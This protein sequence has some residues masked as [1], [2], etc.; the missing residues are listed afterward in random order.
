[1]NSVKSSIVKATLLIISANTMWSAC[2][3]YSINRHIG[4]C[5]EEMRPAIEYY[6][7][8]DNMPE[9]SSV[10]NTETT[11]MAN[12]E[13]S[14]QQIEDKYLKTTYVTKMYDIPN[15]DTSFKSYM[16]YKCITN[17]K[18]EQ[19]KLQTKAWTDDDGLRRFGDAYLVAMGTYYSDHC[20]KKF[21]VTF[22]TNETIIVMVGDIKNDKHT[23][24]K[25]QYSP[26]YNEYGELIS[27]NVLEFIVDTSELN[28]KAKRLGSVENCANLKGNIISIIE[29]EDN[30]NI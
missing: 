26:V 29:I 11:V 5:V 7:N 19:Y 16:S 1:M 30:K 8:N 20:G 2:I 21:E 15:M 27:A 23:D 12:Q 17:K 24:S 10:I 3:L 14:A 4:K 18:S 25:N 22:D 28:K 6:E 9:P 13:T